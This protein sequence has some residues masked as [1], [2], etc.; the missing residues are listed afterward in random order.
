MITEATPYDIAQLGKLGR[1]F[2]ERSSSSRFI[3]F[4]EEGFV[5]CLFRLLSLGTI[6]VW[7]A[8]EEGRIAG[9][10]GLLI[11]PNLYNPMELLGDIYFIDVL[12]EYQKQG[13]AGKLMGVVEEFAKLVGIKALTV[14]F[15]QQEIADKICASQGFEAL[16]YKL[17][18]KVG[19]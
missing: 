12:P 2:I 4:D 13:I 14:S 16:E 9:A 19:D 3:T 1:A 7:V 11:S 10:V 18:K 17:I 8:K 6:R 5:N 15:K